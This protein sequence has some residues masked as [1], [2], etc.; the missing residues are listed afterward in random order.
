MLDPEPFLD[1]SDASNPSELT[2]TPDAAESVADIAPA[3]AERESA[4]V[5]AAA[6]A[7]QRC[8][9][10]PATMIPFASSSNTGRRRHLLRR[11]LFHDDAVHPKP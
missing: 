3:Q 6:A 1:P 8:G 9:G 11:T 10:Q 2:D 5:P 4:S 7:S